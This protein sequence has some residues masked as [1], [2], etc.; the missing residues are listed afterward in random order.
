MDVEIIGHVREVDP[1]GPAGDPFGP[2]AIIPT[3]GER[4]FM[5]KR[6]SD[7]VAEHGWAFPLNAAFGEL[8][9][10]NP[11]PLISLEQFRGRDLENTW[12]VLGWGELPL[13][14]EGELPE[15]LP[16]GPITPPVT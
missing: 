11:N 9:E 15:N 6:V 5:A 1:D 3:T 14:P 8:L 13:D 16:E 2:W 7:L 12:V 4:V 10:G